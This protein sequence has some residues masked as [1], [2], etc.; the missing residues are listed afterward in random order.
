MSKKRSTPY[1]R[2]LMDDRSK[3]LYDMMTGAILSDEHTFHYDTSQ[4]PIT[5]ARTIRRVLIGVLNDNPRMFWVD[6]RIDIIQSGGMISVGLS[7]NGYSDDHQGM[8][9]R[10]ESRC[11]EIL[12]GL[13]I[14]WKDDYG[15][16]VAI[17]DYL[18]SEVGYEQTDGPDC[19]CII[20][21]LLHSKGVCDGISDT[22]NLLMNMAGVRCTTI[23][24]RLH[25]D[26][27]GHAW[28]ISIIDNKA[29]HTD[30]TFDL[31]GFHRFLNLDDDTMALT[32]R[33][34][35]YIRCDSMESNYHVRNGTYFDTVD[36]ADLYVRRMV[37]GPAGRMEFMTAEP[38][39]PEHFKDVVRSAGVVGNG[40][41]RC[42]G[43]GRGFIIDFE[44]SSVIKKVGAIPNIIGRFLSG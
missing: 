1:H 12:E 27:E 29:Y 18:T 42:T 25:D 19:H 40:S 7:V 17:H 44:P 37:R 22:Y 8:L 11:T 43:D 31:G 4:I 9:E 15:K 33:F 34:N 23:G 30:V 38:S 21:P 14:S 6:N 24:G 13:D 20:G 36:G 5:D 3:A 26:P 16:S 32:H 2:H 10:I 35:R 28:N 41:Y 39:D